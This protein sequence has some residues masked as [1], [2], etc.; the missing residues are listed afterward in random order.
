MI[1]GLAR[2]KARAKAHRKMSAANSPLSL[3]PIFG[4]VVQE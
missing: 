4:G 3:E 2:D 1:G